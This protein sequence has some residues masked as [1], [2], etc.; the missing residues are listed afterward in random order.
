MLRKVRLILLLLQIS[1]EIVNR[2][3]IIEKKR[4]LERYRGFSVQI[5]KSKLESLN[6]IYYECQRKITRSY[7]SVYTGGARAPFTKCDMKRFVFTTLKII[8]LQTMNT[9]TSH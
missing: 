3:L 1:R 5:S 7:N 2:M 6:I 9:E 4:I 8:T